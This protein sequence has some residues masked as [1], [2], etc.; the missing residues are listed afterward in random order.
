MKTRNCRYPRSSGMDGDQSGESGAFLFSRHVPDFCDVGDHSRQMKTQICI[1]GDVGDGFRSLPIPQFAGLHPPITQVSIFGA[2]S[3]SAQI[4]R[5]NQREN[6]GDYPIYLGRS[7]K[8]KSPDRR[9]FSRLWKP[10]FSK[11]IA[12]TMAFSKSARYYLEH[13]IDSTWTNQ[14]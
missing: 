13:I 12:K 6:C 11:V 3:I 7:A 14:G 2:L 10:G 9:G 4:H 8:S 1:V 5:E